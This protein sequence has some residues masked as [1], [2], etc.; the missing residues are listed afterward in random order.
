[1]NFC[2]SVVPQSGTGGGKRLRHSAVSRISKQKNF[3]F[4]LKEKMGREKIKK[5]RENFSVLLSRLVGWA[6][7]LGRDLKIRRI[8]FKE[9]SNIVQ[10][11]P[12]IH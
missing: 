6:E 3:L 2:P 12:P 4:L 9:S 8:L 11:A 5:C 7:T 10:K 1:M